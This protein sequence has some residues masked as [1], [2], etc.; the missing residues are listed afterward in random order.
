IDVGRAHF[1]DITA[2]SALDKVVLRFRREGTEV[3]VVGLDAASATLVDRFALHDKPGAV[4]QL[5]H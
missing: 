5:M 3:E 1:W 2:I 4:E